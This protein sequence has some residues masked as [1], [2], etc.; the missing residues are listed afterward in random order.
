[1]AN[2]QEFIDAVQLLEPVFAD[3]CNGTSMSDQFNCDAL[4]TLDGTYNKTGSGTVALNQGFLIITS[5]STP[6]IIKIQINALQYTETG[7]PVDEVYEYQSISIVNG[8]YTK[9]ANATSLHSNRGY[10]VGIIY[11]DE[12]SRASTAL[13]SE[14]NN[15]HFACGSS[16]N[17][18]KIQVQIP[19]SQTP[20]SWARY[21]KFCIKADKENYNTIYTNLFFEDTTLGST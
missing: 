10:E 15:E 21:Y 6:N 17:Q 8:E 18:N 1:M 3:S 5:Q 11:L 4:Q 2:S 19:P 14:N 9:I 20:P 13:V 16:T 12:F 7:P